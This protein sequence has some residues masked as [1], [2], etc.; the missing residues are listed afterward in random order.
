M[1]SINFRQVGILTGA[2]AVLM[3][4]Q[5]VGAAQVQIT[6]VQVQSNNNG[7]QLVLGLAD[8]DTI[9]QVLTVVQG[10]SLVAEILASELALPEGGSTFRQNNPVPGIARVEMI[11]VNSETVRV[12]VSGENR[13]PV[14][15]ILRQQSGQLVFGFAPGGATASGETP[16]V[17]AQRQTDEVRPLPPP[18]GNAPLPSTIPLQDPPPQLTVPENT[19]NP[20]IPQPEGNLP[21]FDPS[22]FSQTPRSEVLVPNPAITIEGS[23]ATPAAPAQPIAPAPPFLPRA[24][25]P[26]VG[27][28]AVANL[29]SSPEIIDLGTSARV[30]NIVLQDAP[31]REVLGLLARSADLNLIFAETGEG[32]ADGGPTIS[33]DLQDEPVQDVFNYVIQAA[34]LQAARR[35]RTVFVGTE[36]PQAAKNI[37]TRTFRLNQVTASSAANFLATQGAEV[38]LLVELEEDIINPQTQERIGTRQLPPRLE[39]ITPEVDNSLGPLLLVGTSVAADSR[40]NTVTIVGEPRKVQ[41]ATNFLKQLDARRRQV[42]VNV[43]IIDV[44]LSNIGRFGTSFSFGINDTG[45]INQSGIGIINFGTSDRNVPLRTTTG[46]IEPRSADPNT[47]IGAEP[48]Q[49]GRG[50]IGP[51]QP[52]IGLTSETVGQSAVATAGNPSFNMVNAFLLQLQASIQNNNAKILT[53]PTLI[54]QEGQTAA[55]NLTQDVVTNIETDVQ[56]AAGVITSTVTV[57]VSRGDAGVGLV[58]AVNVERIDD[59]GFITMQVS[60]QVSTI[61]EVQTINIG[62]SSNNISLLSRRNLS[63]GVVRMRDGQTLILSGIIQDQ[64]RVQVQKVPILADIPL[65]GSLFRRTNRTNQRNEVIVMVTPQVLD[66]SERFGGTGYTYTPGQESQQMLQ[67]QGFPVPGQP[68]PPNR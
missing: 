20:Q 61:G 39:R 23:P 56:A 57:E 48:F 49:V 10:N 5:P 43:K 33:L 44:N 14:G 42:A 31:V 26:P 15:Q 47:F 30:P 12:I 58:L 21:Q 60:P 51:T 38:Q 59:N 50:N 16:R 45:V 7:F 40:L 22:L 4:S 55:V 41:M 66:D 11:Q 37:V 65:I 24:V 28:I 13:P 32:G 54:V 67:Q 36:L 63:T 35:G 9:P 29:D 18:Q 8:S 1:V 19:V 46:S 25:A 62:G 2:A 64:D 3:V 17:A 68:V 52:S 27:D 53:D 6:Q 34:G